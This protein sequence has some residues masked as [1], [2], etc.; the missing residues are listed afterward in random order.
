LKALAAESAEDEALL[1]LQHKYPKI[2][3]DTLGPAEWPANRELEWNPPGHGDVYLALHESGLLERLMADGVRYAFISNSDNLGARVEPA[4][5]GYFAANDFS[6]MMEVAEKT[7]ADLKGGHLARHLNGRLILRE[8]AQCPEDEIDAFQNI[9]RYRYFNTNN[10][11]VRLDRVQDLVRRHRIIQLPMILNPKTLDPRDSG[12]PPVF[13]I[14]SAM[15]AAI[16]MFSETEAVCVPRSRFFPVKTTNDLLA[17]RSDAFEYTPD[18][19][20]LRC[21]RQPGLQAPKISLDPEHYK[22][23]DQLEERFPAGAPSLKDCAALRVAGDVRFG[24][25]V[26]IRGNVTVSNTGDRQ[27]VIPADTVIDSDMM[28]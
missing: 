15:G 3:Q 18:H 13:Q 12:S 2:L 27:A 24:K 20:L 11:W 8:A 26:I 14:E 1:F 7:P 19:S 28:L 22:K 10:I 5:L 21:S 25:G 23:I 9:E 17:V 4:L 6:F 16:S